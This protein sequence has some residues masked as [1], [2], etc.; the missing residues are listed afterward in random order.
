MINEI[1]SHTIDDYR[2]T[3]FIEASY[4]KNDITKVIDF[5]LFLEDLEEYC[6]LFDDMDWVDYEDDYSSTVT[7]QK[8]IDIL[9]EEFNVWCS[10]SD[11]NY[12]LTNWHN[13][14]D[15]ANINGVIYLKLC[16]DEKGIDFKINDKVVNYIPCENELIIFPSYLWHHPNVSITD[17]KRISLNLELLTKQST[18]DLFNEI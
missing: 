6:E 8:N 10:V 4:N 11:K 12:T 15:T 16:S 14:Q 5:E 1:I 18:K 2:G 13:H 3:I 17:E 9:E 7:I